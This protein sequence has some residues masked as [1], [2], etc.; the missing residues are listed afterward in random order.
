MDDLRTELERLGERARPRSDAFERLGRRRRRVERNRR[1]A[2]GAVALL[3]AVAGS[4][5]AFAV[6]RDSETRIAGEG[7]AESFRA[8][9]PETSYEEALAV[10][11]A[12]VA[13]DPNLAWRLDAGE[14]ALAFARDALGWSDATLD[15]TLS[16]TSTT[17]QVVVRQPPASCESAPETGCRGPE[18]TVKLAQPLGSDGI[19]SVV[20]AR[21]DEFLEVP[22]DGS[23]VVAGSDIEIATDLSTNVYVA[24]VGLGPCL[25]WEHDLITAVSG[26][27]SI[28]VPDLPQQHLDGCDVALVALHADEGTYGASGLGL[29]LLEYGLRTFV[30]GVL[31]LPVR[32]VP[33]DAGPPAPDVATFRCDGT[34]ATLDTSLIRTQPDGVHVD[35][36]NSADEPL[37]FTF[38][39]PQEWNSPDSSVSDGPGPDG[40]VYEPGRIS[41]VGLWAPG[42]Y[43]VV[44]WNPTTG[45]MAAAA[46]L[47]VVDPAGHYVPWEPECDGAAWGMAPGYAEGATGDRGDPL[48]VARAR[49]TRLEEGDVVERALYPASTTDPVIRIVRG[50][51]VFVAA[52]L[53]DDGQGGWLL[54]SLEGCGEA[55]TIG[56]SSGEVDIPSGEASDPDACGAPTTDVTIVAR[57]EAFEPSCVAVPAGESFTITLVNGDGDVPHNVSIYL[58]GADDPLFVG[59]V[60]HGGRLTDEVPGLAAGTYLLVDDAHPQTTAATLLVE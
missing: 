48:D 53:F 40:D 3:V 14:T 49:L 41:T 5:A 43:S 47:E 8:I 1:I 29:H 45:E 15:H 56:W 6:F 23:E 35:F 58:P 10:Q 24:F 30:Y 20:S 27:V 7:G 50:G 16:D 12:V 19:W 38:R 37:V 52:T 60:C 51:R 39:F 36:V 26:S 18:V 46:Q 42:T 59:G 32:L 31:A 33:P 44:C 22:A 4:L 2:A 25:G 28:T 9:W 17:S 55:Q 13:G 34:S 54:G 21:S 11:E 57:D